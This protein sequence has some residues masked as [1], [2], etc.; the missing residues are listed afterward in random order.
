MVPEI[1]KKS[2]KVARKE[3]KKRAVERKATKKAKREAPKKSSAELPDKLYKHHELGPL[4]KEYQD[5]GNTARLRRDLR[6]LG[7]KLSDPTTWEK[8]L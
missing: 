4:L 1:T 2:R 6:A 3:A 7:F 8:F 5:G